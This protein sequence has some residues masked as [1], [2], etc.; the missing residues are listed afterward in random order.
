MMILRHKTNYSEI[1]KLQKDTKNF[2]TFDIIFLLYFFTYNK[3][4]IK[5]MYCYLMNV[6]QF[7]FNFI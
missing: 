5:E 3:K 7:T 2:N 1:I 4:L 6:K